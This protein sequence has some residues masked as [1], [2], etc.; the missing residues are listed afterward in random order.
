M[1]KKNTERGLCPHR[2]FKPCNPKCVHYRKGMR[3]NEKDKEPVPFEDCA[4]NIICDNIEMT[5][6]RIF[7]LQK[8]MGETKNA[9]LFQAI[10]TLTN[11]EET[12]L[13][14]SRMI[15]SAGGM[16]KL[17]GGNDEEA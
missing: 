8:E 4:I 12:K 5:H 10:A 9:V 15:Q 17:L 16:N 7:T 13:M 6:Q 14:L 3:Y 1:L 11:D 2:N